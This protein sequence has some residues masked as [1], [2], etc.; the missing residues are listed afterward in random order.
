M[1]RLLPDDPNAKRVDDALQEWRQGDV[2]RDAEAFVHVADLTVPLTDVAAAADGENVVVVPYTIEGVVVLSQTCDIVRGCTLQPFVEVAPL[3]EVPEKE[4]HEI[5]RGYRPGYA[6]VPSLREQ[7]LVADLSRVMTVEKSVVAAWT[8][9]PGCLTDEHTRTF[10]AALARKRARFAFPDDFN[11]LMKKLQS[12]MTDKHEKQSE[13]G[14]ALRALREIRVTASPAWDSERVEIF[15]WFIRQEADA[16]FEAKT[17]DT[18]LKSWLALAPASGRFATVEGAVVTLEGM[19]AKDY[20]E[21]D[22]LDL[23]FLSV[24]GE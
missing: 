23:D 16:T 21:S 18:W 24:R 3:V 2:A 10:G 15:I 4:A 20:V 13:E 19:T 12:R 8:R 22:I 7:R 14:R 6:I 11:A 1:A 5:V 9:T 17:W